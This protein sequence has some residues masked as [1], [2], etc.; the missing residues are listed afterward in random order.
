MIG[1]AM[2]AEKNLENH[3]RIAITA[4]G[5]WV[6]K[7]HG[8]EFQEGY[9]DLFVCYHGRFIGLEVKAPGGHPS[10]LQIR[11]LQA[12]R[13]SGAIAELIYNMELLAQILDC[14]DAGTTWEDHVLPCVSK[15]L[16]IDIPR[17]KK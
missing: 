11:R 4:R 15:T 5:G 3:L 1:G 6:A 2:A 8:N 16:E 17:R 12:L 14:V 10:A 7:I 13:R 9:P